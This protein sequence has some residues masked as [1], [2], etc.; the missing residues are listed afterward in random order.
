MVN[1]HKHFGRILVDIILNLHAFPP[2][3]ICGRKG[4]LTTSELAE[5]EAESLNYIAIPFAYSKD[6]FND[7][8]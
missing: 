8:Q 7:K 3:P 1:I 2:N 6:K 4:R 5:K